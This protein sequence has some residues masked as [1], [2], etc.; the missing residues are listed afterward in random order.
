MGRV[1]V[2]P[3]IQMG[4]TVVSFKDFLISCMTFVNN[5]GAGQGASC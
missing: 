2:E 1:G 3:I 5:L 4:S